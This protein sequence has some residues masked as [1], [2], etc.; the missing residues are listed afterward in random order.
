MTQPLGIH[1]LY[2][3]YDCDP[4]LLD[5][6]E[7]MRKILWDAALK[8]GMTPLEEAS[9]RYQPQGVSV[10]IL[11]AESH[12][13]IHTW[14]EHGYAAVDLFSCRTSVN[15]EEVH[16]FLAAALAPGRSESQVI[17]RGANYQST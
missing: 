1:A 15:T 9:H 14:P 4:Q 6:P 10:V 5:S 3:F 11:V 17:L 8:A 13:S 16:D 12:I 7:H 2:E